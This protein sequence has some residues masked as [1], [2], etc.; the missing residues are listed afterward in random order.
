MHLLDGQGESWLELGVGTGRLLDACF[1]VNAPSTY[2]GVEKDPSLL[3]KCGHVSAGQLVHADVLNP[4]ALAQVLGEQ[5]FT[6]SV[7]NPPYGCAAL[8]DA[9]QNRINALCPGLQLANEWGNLDLYFVLESLSRLSRPGQAG[10]IVS[11]AVAADVRLVAFRKHLIDVASEVLCYELPL[12]TFG[13]KAEVQSYIL[14]AKFGRTKRRC[15]VKVG[16]LAGPSFD[17]AEE[18]LVHPDAGAARLDLGHHKFADLTAT[19]LASASGFTMREMGASIVRGSRTHHQFR[20][21][22]VPH[23]HTSDFPLSGGHVEF[24]DTVPS[25]FQ[26]ACEGDILVPRVGSRCLDRHALVAT[27]SRPYTEAVYRVRVPSRYVDRIASWIGSDVGTEWRMAAAKGV[28]AKHLT[29]SA[30]MQMPV[31][32]G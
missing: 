7:G 29:V 18:R 11:A 24:D 9:A 12:D 17:V 8:P 19:L 25:G 16:R 21:L 26:L 32:G 30:L 23:F 20:D 28:C 2:I 10:F 14:I 15:I 27:G 13:R 3:A 1:V 31:L 22:G 6:R 5:A 4:A